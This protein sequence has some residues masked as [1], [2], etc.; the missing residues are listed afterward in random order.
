MFPRLRVGLVFPKRCPHK[1]EAQAREAPRV[2]PAISFSRLFSHRGHR[3]HGEFSLI[4]FL[5]V[6]RALC[7]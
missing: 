7:G 6:L 5:G 3:D 4:I 1:S 2:T